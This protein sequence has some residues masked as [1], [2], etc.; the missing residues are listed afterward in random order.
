MPKGL[1]TTRNLSATA[2]AIKASGCAF[3][4]RYLSQSHWKLVEQPEV[5]A[6]MAA[7]LNLVLVYEDAPTSTDYF[8]FGR[9]QADGA[10]AAQQAHSVSA[11]AGTVLYFAVDYD[12]SS[13]AITGVIT[14]Y[15]NGVS[16]ALKSFSASDDVTYRVG[17]YGSGATCAAITGRGLA[18]CGWLAQAHGWAGFDSYTDWSIRQAMPANIAGLSVDP[19]DATGN[20]GAMTSA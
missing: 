9:G 6:I 8:S 14:Q 2:V 18:S 7:G 13:D 12:A 19:D 4:A 3:V 17:V 1:D 16:N 5:D 11:P 15:F 10:R 20:Y